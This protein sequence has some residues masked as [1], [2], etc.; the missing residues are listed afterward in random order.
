MEIK[1]HTFKSLSYLLCGC[2]KE[3]DG[4]TLWECKRHRAENA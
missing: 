4:E 2:V 1:T 3:K